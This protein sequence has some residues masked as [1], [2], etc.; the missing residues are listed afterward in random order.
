MVLYVSSVS[1]DPKG[2]SMSHV[3][4]DPAPAVKMKA[5]LEVDH[6]THTVAFV[7]NQLFTKRAPFVVDHLGPAHYFAEV[8]DYGSM[9]IQRVLRLLP[10]VDQLVV[11]HYGMVVNLNE[12]F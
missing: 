3:I 9:A 2:L 6:D 8:L 12:L 4:S 5:K 7:T 11:Q 1:L 10:G